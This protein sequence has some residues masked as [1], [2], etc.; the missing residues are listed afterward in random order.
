MRTAPVIAV[1]ALETGGQS[2]R[3]SIALVAVLSAM[4]LVVLDAA[5]INVAIPTVAD[6]LLAAPA[7]ALRVVSVYQTAVVMA[8][9]PC[10]ALGE[11]LGNRRVFLGG[12]MLFAAASALAASA[13]SLDQLIAARFLQ[14]LGGAAIMALGIALLRQA[15]PARQFGAAIGW[16]AMVVALCSAAG[17]TL[18][19]IVISVASWKWL[20]LAHLPLAALASAAG[21]GL[22]S[23]SGTGRRLDP[24][25][26]AFSAAGFGSLMFGAGA[27]ASRPHLAVLLIGASVGLFRTLARREAPKPSPVVPVDLLGNRTFRLAV[28]ASICCFTGQAAAMLALPFHLQQNLGQTPLKAGLYMTSWPLAVAVAAFVTGRLAERLPSW[29]LCAAGASLIAIGL[30]SAALFPAHGAPIWFAVLIIPCGFGFGIFQVANNRTMFLSAP[31]TRS[32]AAGGLQG[33]ARLVGQTAGS[34]LLALLF[35]WS[36]PVS[37]P[38]TGFAIGA[39]FALLAAIVSAMQAPARNLV[40]RKVQAHAELESGV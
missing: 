19:A 28:L 8:L 2:L 4:A 15:L 31:V 33:T 6:A 21:A 34:V 30:V 9:L 13:T 14:G 37:A 12:L 29:L 26:M 7:S 38:I 17:P 23:G 27:F 25:S 1:P 11:S 10:A 18:G 36:T 20:F 35:A 16:N 5:M 32:A 3:Q 24:L 22:P 40:L 39:G